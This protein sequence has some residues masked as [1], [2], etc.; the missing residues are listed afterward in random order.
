MKVRS[1]AVQIRALEREIG[2]RPRRRTGQ[3]VEQP[4]VDLSFQSAEMCGR[5][6]SF[7]NNAG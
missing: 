2:A 1:E 7:M 5:S 6:S 3:Y 4:S